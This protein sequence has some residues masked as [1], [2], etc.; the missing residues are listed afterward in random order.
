MLESVGERTGVRGVFSGERECL[1]SGT[2][3]RES[4][5]VEVIIRCAGIYSRNESDQCLCE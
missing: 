4:G 3:G 1:C 5:E 2:A